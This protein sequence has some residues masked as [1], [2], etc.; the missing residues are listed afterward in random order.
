MSDIT[1]FTIGFTKKTAEK[2]FEKLKRAGVQKVVDVRLNN[3]SQ[4]AGFTKRADLEYFL[5]ELA[6]IDYVHVPELA[7]TKEM[8]DALKKKKGDW[9]EFESPFLDLMRQRQIESVLNRD[10][11]DRGCLLCS[12]DKPHHCHR[13][14]VAKYLNEEWGGI[15]VEHL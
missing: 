6:G 4:L 8:F 13:S 12:E 10:L 7:P 3:V 2:F 11:I 15:S 1:L 14:L 9:G 5:R